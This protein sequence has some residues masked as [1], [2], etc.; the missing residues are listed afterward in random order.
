MESFPK[1]KVDSSGFDNCSAGC[2]SMEAMEYSPKDGSLVV[3]ETKN[4]ILT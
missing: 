1:R 4:A 3:Q 2:S